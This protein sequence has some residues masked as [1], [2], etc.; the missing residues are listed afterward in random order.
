MLHDINL[1]PW[2]E[3]KRTEYKQRFYGMVVLGV[4]VAISLQWFGSL[5]IDHLKTQQ[6]SRNQELKTYIAELDKKLVNLKEI[7]A[8][9]KSILTRLRLVESLQNERNK[10]TDFMN[11]MPELVPEGVY[12]DK[13]K[14]NGREI[15]MSGVSDSTSRLATMLDNFESSSWLSDVEMHSIISGKVLFGKKFQSFKLSFRFESEETE[16]QQNKTVNTQAKGAK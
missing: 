4:L 9:H 3:E 15:E 11:L 6:Q 14:M 10:T 8:K 2:R 13:I 16:R 7:E 1:L 12:V 5:Y